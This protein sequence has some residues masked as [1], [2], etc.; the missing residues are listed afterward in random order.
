MNLVKDK[1]WSVVGGKMSLIDMLWSDEDIELVSHLGFL[2][3]IQLE[4]MGA[5]LQAVVDSTWRLGINY[6]N[7]CRILGAVRSDDVLDLLEPITKKL[8]QVPW[9]ELT[10]G[11][12]FM[13]MPSAWRKEG[14][15]EPIGN[16]MWPFQP[17]LG[18]S[19]NGLRRMQQ[20][21]KRLNPELTVL[22]LFSFQQCSRGYGQYWS[23]GR[24]ANNPIIYQL[25]GK[26]LRQKLF[27]AVLPGFV[28][29]WRPLQRLP[30]VAD[31]KNNGGLEYSG[32]PPWQKC[33]RKKLTG[34][35]NIRL[36]WSRAVVLDVPEQG[37][38]N[39]TGD[40]GD[41][42]S[43]Y[44][45]MSETK[46]FS[47]N[48][49]KFFVKKAAGIM[50]A[51][52]DQN[53]AHPAAVANLYE[54]SKKHNRKLGKEILKMVGQ[55]VSISNEVLP[56]IAENLETPLNVA[57]Q[58]Y[59]VTLRGGEVDGNK[60]I[61]LFWVQ[62]ESKAKIAVKGCVAQSYVL[63]V[64]EKRNS[65][66]ID[67]LIKFVLSRLQEIRAAI[68]YVIA[69]VQDSEKLSP[70]GYSIAN[71]F[72]LSINVNLWQVAFSYFGLSNR[73]GGSICYQRDV[74]RAAFK[75]LDD[76][77]EQL[78]PCLR[79]IKG[80][81]IITQANQYLLGGG[82]VSMDIGEKVLAGRAFAEAYLGLNRK[83][84]CQLRDACLLNRVYVQSAFWHCYKKAVRYWSNPY[85]QMFERLVILLEYVEH[86]DGSGDVGDILVLVGD[87]VSEAKIDELF[88]GVSQF[89][90]IELLGELFSIRE[91]K[92]GKIIC[93]FGHLVNDVAYY[94]FQPDKILRKW[95]RSIF[96][97]ERRTKCLS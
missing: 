30:W 82:K 15:K 65:T 77:L 89:E 5:M 26:T 59:F 2:T 95:A 85:Q 17:R 67:E 71:R 42:F 37:G 96:L 74:D 83:D 93:D 3:H 19:E 45:I 31:C 38:C 49:K 57:I 13:Q 43:S 76:I 51:I 10:G 50:A 56:V 64:V 20:Y 23:N 69:A 84:Q 1:M 66:A 81:K 91:N 58:K 52:F 39:F 35:A 12:A 79:G 24:L 8:C 62:F 90:L 54:I 63:E 36:A 48:K 97:T 53:T 78:V 40:V 92:K 75:I 87:V 68:L 27:C 9:F 73:R 46:I 21:P 44:R 18:G 22:F 55:G 41:V 28:K 11:S 33:F 86:K 14:K 70:K 7:Y 32:Q 34:T 6:E 60:R 88:W 25:T 94:H 80:Y 72:M 61:Y 47:Q 4:M 16:L 29:D